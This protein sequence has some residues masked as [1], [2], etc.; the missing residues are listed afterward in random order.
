MYQEGY[1]ERWLKTY[2]FPYAL[3]DSA[4]KVLL[5]HTVSI[6]ILVKRLG[7][8]RFHDIQFVPNLVGK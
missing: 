6:K 1:N 8:V 3:K 7:F 2:L 5:F 4:T